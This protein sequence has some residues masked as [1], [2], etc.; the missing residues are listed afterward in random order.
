MGLGIFGGK[1]LKVGL[2]KHRQMVAGAGSGE[3]YARRGQHVG[4]PWQDGLE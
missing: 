3:I 1:D 4:C 2:E